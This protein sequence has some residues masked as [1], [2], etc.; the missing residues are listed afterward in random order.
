MVKRR[1]WIIVFSALA[2]LWAIFIW[3][4]SLKPGNISGEMSSSVLNFINEILGKISPRWKISH[5]LVRK[6]AHFLEFAVMGA[7]CCL[8]SYFAFL[9]GKDSKSICMI[10]YS[11]IPSVAVAAIDETIQ[12]FVEGRAGRFTD[13]LIDSSGAL[14][15]V[16]IFFF[17]LYIKRLHKKTPAA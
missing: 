3:S 11:M 12:L 14:C 5:L 2:F 4:N 6:A 15:S 8:L 9:K 7:L 1:F 10:F 17:I 16:L 13:V